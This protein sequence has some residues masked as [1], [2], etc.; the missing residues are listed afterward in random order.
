MER[1][2]NYL[3]QVQQAKQYFLKYDQQKLVEKLK[4]RQ[5]ETYLYTQMMGRPYRI[6]RETGDLEGYVDD[7]W[8]DANTHGEFMTLM[9]L[10]C[11]S[12]PDRYTTGNW[13]TMSAFGNLFHRGLLESR[14]PFAEAV[15]KDP[16]AFC[17]ACEAM[18][19]SAQP[20]GD[21]SYAIEVFDGL[22][23]CLQFWGSDEDFPAQVVWF[24]D[25]NALM[26]LKYETMYFAVGL[27]KRRILE[28][29]KNLTV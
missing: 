22:R 12:R 13:K 17:R 8:A 27:M 18:G 23:I 6:H 4:L 11:D 1:K 29:M 2:D 7:R 28:Q 25:E 9:D 14:D 24:W 10:V 15:E 21:I 26:Y 5:D 3:L 16:D 20:I 19:G